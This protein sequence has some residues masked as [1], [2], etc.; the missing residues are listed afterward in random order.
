MHAP[1]KP[2]YAV[3][4]PN[5]LAH[6]DG[7]LLGIPTRFGNMPAQFKVRI[8]FLSFCFFIGLE[9]GFCRPSGMAPASSGNR[10]SCTASPL[11]CLSR[12]VAPVVARRQLSFHPSRPWLIMA[13]T[14]FPL[15]TQL[16]SD[17]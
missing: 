6:Y 12:P 15:A 16:P 14:L 8:Y 4:E 13:S 5:D 17:S 11:A 9:L 2:S 7:F 3:L 1:P 10:A